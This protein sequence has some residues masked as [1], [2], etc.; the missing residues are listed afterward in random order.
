MDKNSWFHT[1]WRPM[2]GWTW[3]VCIWFDLIIAPFL[4]YSLQHYWIPGTP[5]LK[6]ESFTMANGGLFHMVMAGA[7]GVTSYGRTLEKLQAMKNAAA[8]PSA[9][10]ATVV[11]P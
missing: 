1:K 11:N 7:C 9:A 2:M 4:W 10:P 5:P 3:I 6:W 8:V